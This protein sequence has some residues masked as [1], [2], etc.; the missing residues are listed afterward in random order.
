ML[1]PSS[2]ALSFLW[3][4]VRR[5]WLGFLILM[6]ASVLWALSDALFPYFIKLIVNALQSYPGPR[7][8]VLST[9]GGTLILLVSFWLLSELVNRSQGILAIYVFPRFRAN[10]R[11]SVFNYVKS[12]SHSYFA[13][14]FAGNLAKKLG[15]LPESCQTLMESIC[16]SFITAATGAVVVIGMMWHIKPIFAAMLLLWLLMHM[17]LTL[18]LLRQGVKVWKVHSEAVSLLSGKIVDVFTNIVNVKLFARNQHEREYLKSFQADEISKAKK[19]MWLVELTRIGLGLS[20]L[21]LIFSMMFLL[22]YGWIHGWVTLGD[23][24]QVGMQSFWLLGWI[25]FVSYQL[26]LFIREI[27]TISAALSIINKA[28]DIVDLPQAKLLQVSHGKIDFAQV[29]F[30]YPNNKK[31]FQDLTIHIPSGQKVGL[32]GFSGSGKTS[33]VNL[34]LRFFDID[35]GKICIDG[36]NIAEVSQSSLRGKIAMIPQDPMLFHRS[37]MENIRYGR[38]EASDE[39][40][41]AASKLAHCDEFIMALTEGYAAL[42]GERGIKLSGG[43]RQ[44]IAIARAI[45]KDAPILILDEATSALDSSTERLIYESLENLMQ[46]RTAIVIAHRLSTLANMDRILVFDQGNIV[47]DGSRDDLLQKNGHFAH[48]WNMQING[49]LPEN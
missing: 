3:F 19:A 49:F 22:V 7:E 31:I 39:E 38:L 33:F 12:H 13:N 42:V 48:L 6:L 8:Q 47:E 27:G 17:S 16:F 14:Q 36:Q 18:I 25:W 15:D 44:R 30:S 2:S 9:I 4:F 26:T 10:I 43:Q 5:Q 37:L 11:G 45:L 28:H 29:N 1:L 20:G 32:V 24:T 40:V 46:N 21:F 41:I 23:F 35:S 34:I